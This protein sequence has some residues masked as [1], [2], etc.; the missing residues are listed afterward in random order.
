MAYATV[1]EL[2][3]YAG[4]TPDDAE[5][6]LTRASAMLD[7][8]PL[9]AAVY[10][11]DANGAPTDP[12]VIAA[13]RDAVCAQVQWWDELGDSVGAAGAGWGAV[14]IGGL[15]MSRSVTSVSGS[16]SAARQYA[17]GVADALLS[18]RLAGRLRLGAVGVC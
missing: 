9:Y 4:I 16:D 10:D 18:P 11:V 2:E 8:G 5:R 12:V 3:A 13:L 7:A 14:A 6:L 1:A 15:S 17:P